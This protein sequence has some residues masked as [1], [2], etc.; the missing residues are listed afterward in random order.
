M[1]MADSYNQFK[2][3]STV[4]PIKSQLIQISPCPST[5]SSSKQAVLCSLNANA[6]NGNYPAAASNPVKPHRPEGTWSV[7]GSSTY[8]AP[9]ML[10]A[11]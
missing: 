8:F 1:T 5:A 6:T 3:P 2:Q 9:E 7:S 4:C 11:R 10:S